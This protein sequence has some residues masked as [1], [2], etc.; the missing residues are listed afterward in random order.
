MFVVDTNVLVYAANSDAPEH[1]RCAELVEEWSLSPTP[2]YLTWGIAYEFMRV[3]T[4]PR[5]FRSPL[6]PDQAWRFLSA[7]LGSIA[8]GLL[9]ATDR[10]QSVLGELV[11]SVPKLVGNLYHD[12]ETAALMK[13]HG[14][15]TIVTRDVD[16]H[17]FGFLDVIDPLA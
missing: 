9:V 12:A 6:S 17:R 14:I 8:V 13:E 10:H 2:W 3:V 7:V 15:R 4:H 1:P 5:L 11:A 16:F